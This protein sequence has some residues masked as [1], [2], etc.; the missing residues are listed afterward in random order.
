VKT[1]LSFSSIA[2]PEASAVPLKEMGCADAVLIKGWSVVSKNE[3]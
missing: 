3:P 1:I 2:T